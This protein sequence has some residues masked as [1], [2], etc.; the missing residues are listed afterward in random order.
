MVRGKD[1]YRVC[2]HVNSVCVQN[3]V[4][5]DTYYCYDCNSYFQELK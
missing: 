5:A 2:L 1:L 3:G 4:V